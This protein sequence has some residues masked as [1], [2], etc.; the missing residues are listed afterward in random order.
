MKVRAPGGESYE[1]VRRVLESHR[2]NTVCVE[3]ACPNIRECF[4]NR[5][6]TFLILGNICTRSCRFCAVKHG[7]PEP[8]D[9][10]EPERVATAV[11]DLALRYVVI[12][13]VTRDNLPDGGAAH[14]AMTV[15]KI[16]ELAPECKIELL[17]PDFKGNRQALE[18]VV[19]SPIDV[20]A[21][22]L[23]TV[24]SLYPMV[25]DQ[26]DYSRSLAVLRTT[27]TIKADLPIKSGLMLGLGE[28]HAEVLGTL[29]DLRKVG[30]DL[31][32]LGQYLQPSQKQLSVARYLDP[33]EFRFYQEEALKMD[34]RH[35][36]SGPF[37]RSSY[38]ANQ[39]G[40]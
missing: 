34:F 15:Y 1:W 33:S 32:T 11:R 18:K 19:A 6:A 7:Q 10:S 26:A 20:L 12:T 22:N 24:P 40:V 38:H 23:E 31:L 5:S 25:R 21:H 4:D 37:V 30:C 2:L 36:E 3:A 39:A 14:F 17:I 35:V 8:V 28:T 13:S 16:K 27:K 9:A 29:Q